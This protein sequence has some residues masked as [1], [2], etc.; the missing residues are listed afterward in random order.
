MH[1]YRKK[2]CQAGNTMKYILAYL[3]FVTAVSPAIAQK[4]KW[5]AVLT[6]YGHRE[7]GILLSLTDS[8]IMIAG[9]NNP[10]M[11]VLL[12]D[13]EKIKLVPVRDK[14]AERLVGLFAGSLTGGI[15]GGM[16]LSAKRE[17][18]PA[19]L[20]GVVGGIGIGILSGA[21]CAVAAPGIV[22]LFVTKRYQV[23]HDSISLS[24]L[25]QKITRYCLRP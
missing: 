22:D 2:G 17:G 24:L 16:A 12:K 11:E 14:G 15:A 25:K 3:L 6:G 7:K 1:R 19:A 18:E 4:K 8:S 20:A 10:E 5:K 9:R 21:V 13:I 23:H